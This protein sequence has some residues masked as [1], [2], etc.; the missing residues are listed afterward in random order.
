MSA[1]RVLILMHKRLLALVLAFLVLVD[2]A[3]ATWSIVVVNHRTGEVCVAAAT[4]IGNFDLKP[5]LCVIRV[6]EGGAAAQSVIDSSGMNRL[7]IWNELQNGTAPNDIITLLGTQDSLHQR[8][9][10]G[11]VSVR[12]APAT[13]TGTQCSAAR[14]GVSGTT[15]DLSY[16]IQGNILTGTIVVT[17]AEAAFLSSSGDL[18]TRVMAG[19]LAA[20]AMGGD[21]RCSCSALMP[22]SCGAPPAN[23][24]Q[25]DS[26]AF[27]VSSRLGDVDG[28]CING[29]N[30][31]NGTYW[32]DLREISSAGGF[33]PVL[34]LASDTIPEWRFVVGERADHFLTRVTSSSARIPADGT[35][36]ATVDVELRNLE[37]QPVSPFSASL[38]VVAADSP[39]VAAASAPT[40][41]GGG[42]LRFTLA[43]NG[44]LGTTR[45]WITVVHQSGVRVR[46]WPALELEAVAPAPILLG[47]EVVSA[48]A[49]ASVPVWLDLGATRA[50]S[51]HLVLG[52]SSGTAPGSTFQGVHLPLNRDRFL[53]AS[54]L[55]TLG[56]PF[57][58]TAGVLDANG[59]A[60][61]RFEPPPGW[62]APFIGRRLDWAAYVSGGP[63]IATNAVGLDVGP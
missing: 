2:S 8:R 21:G 31:A 48:S 19:M 18:P 11:I 43:S 34:R 13:F 30:C 58:G 1:E 54:Y 45:Y 9:Q 61:A 41:L 36:A 20:R 12:G 60:V 53:N 44:Q 24:T 3:R 62:L 42:R 29:Q 10:Y 4:C 7:A 63:A 38:E 16:S 23:F 51:M 46:L 59:R 39:A 40:D 55:R 17:N 26:T 27:L 50:G 56:G 35:S 32:C 25:A 49:G 22:T 6:G 15:G 52:T 47:R 5:A 33:D 57:V 14:F 28:T 37:D